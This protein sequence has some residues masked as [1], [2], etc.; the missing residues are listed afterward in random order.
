MN[1]TATGN[2]YVINKNCI[3][4]CLVKLFDHSQSSYILLKAK[5]KYST[6]KALDF[7]FFSFYI[8]KGKTPATVLIL[9]NRKKVLIWNMQ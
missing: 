5:F 8:L 4:L 1:C 3:L 2:Y 7:F 9:H 6:F